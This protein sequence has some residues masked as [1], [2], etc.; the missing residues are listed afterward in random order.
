[1]RRS[2]LLMCILL[3]GC[4]WVTEGVKFVGFQF[5]IPEAAR[6]IKGDETTDWRVIC[7]DRTWYLD[8]EKQAREIGC[9]LQCPVVGPD[10][11]Y[12]HKRGI[13]EK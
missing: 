7:E 6:R 2:L 1:M 9:R 13:N 4:Y 8:G 5:A 3:S 12:V 10:S 11:V